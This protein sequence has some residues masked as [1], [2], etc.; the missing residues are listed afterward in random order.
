MPRLANLDYPLALK[1]RLRPV[2]RMV[3]YRGL[4]EEDVL[5]ASYPRSGSTWLRFLLTD[6]AT[7]EDPSWGAEARIVPDVGDHG[8]APRLLPGGGRLVKTHDAHRGPTKRAVYLVRDVRDVL[9]SEYR[10]DLRHGSDESL[11]SFLDHALHWGTLFGPWD[12]HVDYW[13][14]SP[15]DPATVL[16]VRFEDLRSET[17]QALERIACFLGIEADRS[18]IDTAISRNGLAEM[19]KKEEVAFAQHIGRDDYVRFVG[20]GAV[21]GWNGKLSPAQL[22][23]IEQ[24]SWSTLERLGYVRSER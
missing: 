5:L 20:E 23:R 1:R 3:R 22:A 18:A 13:V 2:V 15:V 21:G 10:F 14:G 7:G 4:T 12:A 8:G 17:A 11:D 24:R 19:R 16:L 9:L 6:L